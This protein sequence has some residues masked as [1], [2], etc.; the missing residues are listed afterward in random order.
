MINIFLYARMDK[1]V[2]PDTLKIMVI[3]KA[4]YDVTLII[5]DSELKLA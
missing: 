4:S 5:P 3:G 1:R 2:T